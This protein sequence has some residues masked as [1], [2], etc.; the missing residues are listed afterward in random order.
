[1]VSIKN[2]FSLEFW[3]FFSIREIEYIKD[4]NSELS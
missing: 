4:K 2:I 1:M 3:F